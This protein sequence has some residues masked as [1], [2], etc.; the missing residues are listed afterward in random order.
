MLEILLAFHH[1]SS[2]PISIGFSFLPMTL[3]LS[4]PPRHHVRTLKV[5]FIPPPLL[6]YWLLGPITY[7]LHLS[8]FQSHCT[9]LKP[10]DERKTIFSY[11]QERDLGFKVKRVPCTTG[12]QWEAA[13]S[14]SSGRWEGR[15]R[16]GPKEQRSKAWK[17]PPGRAARKGR[18][19]LPVSRALERGAPCAGVGR[20]G[21][22]LIYPCPA[23][24]EGLR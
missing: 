19:R 14:G 8:P 7:F 6:F 17:T 21:N 15:V 5:L 24:R 22:W 4:Y 18:S 2:H 13:N 10:Q 16:I 3:S 12:L 9:S 20:G 1:L 11:T 23:S